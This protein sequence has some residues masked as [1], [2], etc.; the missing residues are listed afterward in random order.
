MYSCPIRGRLVSLS[1]K[2]WVITG[3]EK[4]LTILRGYGIILP[5]TEYNRMLIQRGGGTG[6]VKPRQP[7]WR[8]DGSDDIFGTTTAPPNVQTRCQFRQKVLPSER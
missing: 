3:E 6:P 2:I 5:Q 8:L 4:P 7:V 1:P